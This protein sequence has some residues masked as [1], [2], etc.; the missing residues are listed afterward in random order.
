MAEYDIAYFLQS[1]V[2]N[3]YNE[4]GVR[5]GVRCED[6]SLAS[7]RDNITNEDNNTETK[8]SQPSP[9][10]KSSLNALYDIV[11]KPT[12]DLCQG[13][14]IMIV[15]HGPLW[16][17]PYAALLDHEFKYLFESFS[18]RLIPSLTSFKLIAESPEEHHSRTG[19][20]LVGDP[21]VAEIT[22]NKGIPRLQQLKFAKEEVEMI[23]NIIKVTP[24]TGKEATKPEVLKQLSSVQLVHI[25]AHGSMETGE[26]ALS[27]DPARTS[28]NPTKEDYMLTMTDV[29]SVHI[30]ARLVVLSCCHSG[31]GEIKVEG[32]VGIA[33]AFMGA[34]AR[35]VLVT[36]WAIDDEATLEFMKHFY[37]H[38]VEGRSA[39]ESLDQ[40]RK[41]LKES[42][43]FSGVKYW[44]PF[45][46]VGDDV[47]LDLRKR[48]YIFS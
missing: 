41:C 18:V 1:L 42:D 21:W 15:P 25:A 13:K 47:T 40:A 34:G 4:I 46:L 33:R 30:R 37:H 29:L 23:G 20:L 7:L 35:S 2:K 43:K 17:V 24:L 19:S 38:L 26:I 12:A 16:L 27:P 3:S 44:A 31:R 45:V 11:M 48:K 9:L 39:S 36:L 8:T 5:S 28:Q 14:E 10:W 6:R 22:N 32:V